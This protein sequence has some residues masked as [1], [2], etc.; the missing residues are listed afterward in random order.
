[1]ENN[2]VMAKF[3]NGRKIGFEVE[4]RDNNSHE[5][6][7]VSGKKILTKDFLADE[8][9]EDLGTFAIALSEQIKKSG[10]SKAE[11]TFGIKFDVSSGSGLA[12]VI[13]GSAEASIEVKLTWENSDE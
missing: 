8:V 6:T 3:S 10:A 7:L 11:L 5:E 13:S 4:K 12:I 1:M 2:C 9:L